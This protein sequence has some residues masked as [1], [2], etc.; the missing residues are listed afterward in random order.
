MYKEAAPYQEPDMSNMHRLTAEKIRRDRL[1][2]AH[3]SFAKGLDSALAA[4]ETFR[5][6]AT[7]NTAT[8]MR[9]F[10]MRMFEAAVANDDTINGNAKTVSEIAAE[11]RD[12][13]ANAGLDTTALHQVAESVRTSA[14]AFILR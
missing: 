7:G 12:Y 13:A 1:K 8:E 3:P 10:V 11:M 2:A 14:R 5:E 6:A 9:V 4:T